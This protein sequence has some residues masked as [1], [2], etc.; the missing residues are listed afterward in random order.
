MPQPVHRSRLPGGTGCV[1]PRVRRA[2]HR[3][4]RNAETRTSRPPSEKKSTTA[5]EPL[6]KIP[7]EPGHGTVEHV[8]PVLLVGEHMAFAGVDDQLCCDAQRPQRVPELV[9]LRGGALRVA[10]AND[11]ER[12]SFDVLDELYR[13]ALRVHRRVV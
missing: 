9:R 3:I 6:T 7:I 5:P 4:T 11:D 10:L 2:W 13:R 1:A 12:R 8:M